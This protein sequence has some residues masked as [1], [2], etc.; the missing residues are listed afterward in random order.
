MQYQQKRCTDVC[1]NDKVLRD[2]LIV[3]AHAQREEGSLDK[4][5]AFINTTYASAKAAG[6]RKHLA[7]RTR[8]NRNNHDPY[9]IAIICS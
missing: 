3:H 8:Q 7:G 4:Q 9:G 5:D 1:I 2:F 6:S